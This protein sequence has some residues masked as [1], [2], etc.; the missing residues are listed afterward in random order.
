VIPKLIVSLESSIAR[1]G[2]LTRLD[3]NLFEREENLIE[4][5]REMRAREC[6]SAVPAPILTSP[7]SRGSQS[8]SAPNEYAA[9]EETIA[10]EALELIA[11]WIGKAGEVWYSGA[12][13]VAGRTGGVSNRSARC[14]VRS[15]SVS[16][17]RS[18]DL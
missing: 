11:E 7:R 2:D 13:P 10:P 18:R 14:G 12:S 1:D 9:I 15:F 5:D 3:G 4:C 16:S 6:A 17:S 8:P